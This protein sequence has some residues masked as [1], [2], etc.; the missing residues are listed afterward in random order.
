MYVSVHVY[1][2]IYIYIYVLCIYTMDCTYTSLVDLG[3]KRFKI[4]LI[5]WYDRNLVSRVLIK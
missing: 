3:E 2:Y 1:V 4:V 5:F